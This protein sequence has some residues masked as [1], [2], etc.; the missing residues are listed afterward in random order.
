[1]Y[2]VHK[3]SDSDSYTET[4]ERI[5]CQVLDLL[6]FVCGRNRKQALI[7][8][9]IG[10]GFSNSQSPTRSWSCYGLICQQRSLTLCRQVIAVNHSLQRKISEWASRARSCV[11]V[12][13]CV[14]V[15]LYAQFGIV[16]YEDPPC[17]ASSLEQ[18]NRRSAR[19]SCGRSRVAHI[20]SGYSTH[21]ASHPPSLFSDA[22]EFW[23]LKPT[24]L[25]LPVQEIQEA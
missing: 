23:H 24:V 19:A 17:S 22:V 20:F 10:R 4:S 16:E 7:T 9:Y 12:C 14:C 15:A 18:S 2:K 5:N 25:D 1:M 21:L 6:Q 13:V 11:C 8:I 3:P